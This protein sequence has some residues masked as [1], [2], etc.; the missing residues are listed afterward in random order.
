[1]GNFAEV[2]CFSDVF[3]WGKYFIKGAVLTASVE[4]GLLQSKFR[5]DADAGCQIEDEK[6]V[7]WKALHSNLMS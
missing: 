3:S 2:S 4:T 7:Q 6:R 1:M 5:L